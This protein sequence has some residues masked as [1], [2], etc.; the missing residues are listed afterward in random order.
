MGNTFKTALLLTAMTLFLLFVGQLFGGQ[1]GMIIPLVIAVVMNFNSYF[2]SDNIA[3][4]AYRA[5][6]VTREQLP[7]AY[8]IVEHL[9]Q[10]LGIPMPK[11][12]VIPTDSPSAFATGRNPQDAA[13]AMTEGILNLL[14]DEEMEGV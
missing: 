12:Y 13:V 7:R 14:T 10:K 9:T 8:E 1:R 4:G 6:P 3:L 5:Q 2:F 11:I